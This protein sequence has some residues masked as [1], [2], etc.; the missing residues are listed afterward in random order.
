[1]IRLY[2]P[3][4]E[5]P[6]ESPGVSTQWHRLSL[7]H[8]HV[9]ACYDYPSHVPFH[10]I[11]W[12]PHDS[13]CPLFIQIVV[14]I[15]WTVGMNPNSPLLYHTIIV[16]SYSSSNSSTIHY[17]LNDTSTLHPKK[18]PFLTKKCIPGDDLIISIPIQ[19]FKWA[20]VLCFPGT[21]PLVIK[22][23]HGKLLHFIGNSFHTKPKLPISRWFN[24]DDWNIEPIWASMVF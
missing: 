5:S 3:T 15:M 19:P 12:M 22:H 17:P 16:V 1:M 21:H 7:S 18:Q 20:I 2:Q 23:G 13:N 9:Y 8:H 24:L 11:G 6:V 10:G 14:A 4:I